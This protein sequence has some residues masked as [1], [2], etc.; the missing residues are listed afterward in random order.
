M[1]EE[2][3]RAVLTADGVGIEDGVDDIFK[4]AFTAVVEE[5]EG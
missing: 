5:G 1:F 4:F 2:T 3:K